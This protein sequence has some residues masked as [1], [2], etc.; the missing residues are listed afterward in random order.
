MATYEPLTDIQVGSLVKSSHPNDIDTKVAAAFALLPTNAQ[1][2]TGT[3]CYA[4]DTGIADV[5][6]VSMPKT[7]TVYTDGMLVVMKPLF[8]NTGAS[9][10]DVDGIGAKDIKTMANQ[11]PA[12][13]VIVSG[14]PI[15]LRYS[16]TTGDFHI[17]GA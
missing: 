3:I 7:Q 9:T 4:L 16:S 15:S 6:V 10:I 5:Y 1:I 12:A 8:S 14:V 13:G 11:D 17:V 2:N